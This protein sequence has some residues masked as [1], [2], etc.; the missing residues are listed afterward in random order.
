AT[1]CLWPAPQR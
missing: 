1:Y